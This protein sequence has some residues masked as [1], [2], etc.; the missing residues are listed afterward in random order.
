M[1]GVGPGAMEIRLHLL[2]EWRVIYVAR[3]ADAVYVVHAF[4]KKTQK[5][6]AKDIEIARKRYRTIGGKR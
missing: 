3:F 2:G 4:Q 1:P 5:T 6:Q